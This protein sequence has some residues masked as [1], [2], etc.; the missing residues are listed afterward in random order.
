MKNKYSALM[1]G[2]ALFVLAAVCQVQQPEAGKKNGNGG[3]GGKTSAPSYAAEFFIDD[4]LDLVSDGLGLY[5]D[6]IGDVSA[7]FVPTGNPL[8]KLRASSSREAIVDLGNG[9]CEAVAGDEYDETDAMLNQGPVRILGISPYGTVD[10]QGQSVDGNFLGLASGE[11]G[12]TLL[13]IGLKE[14]LSDNRPWSIRF[15]PAFGGAMAAL[16]RPDA[17]LEWEVSTIGRKAVIVR[18]PKRG[19]GAKVVV[20][21][22]EPFNIKYTVTCYDDDQDGLCDPK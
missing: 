5:E 13:G 17:D 6:G 1:R 8:L 18:P 12:M 9:V 16:E 2:L 7:E 11:S 3:G 10:S 14:P 15:D 21:T 20:A 4:G 22:C 19:R